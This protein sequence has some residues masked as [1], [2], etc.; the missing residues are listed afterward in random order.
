MTEEEISR[1]SMA[2]KLK[3]ATKLAEHRN[4]SG[5]TQNMMADTCKVAQS[6]YSRIENGHLGNVSI[7]MLIRMNYLAGTGLKLISFADA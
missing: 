3:L 4:K 2:I 6:R 1:K 5:M 7:D